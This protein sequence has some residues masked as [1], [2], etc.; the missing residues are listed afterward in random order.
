[1]PTESKA[2][3][4]T[5]F[6]ASCPICGAR[7]ASEVVTFPELRFG[8][9]AGCG[10]IYK[11]EQQPGLGDG[12]EEKYFRFTPA[13]YLARWDHRVRKCQRQILACL[14]FAPHARSLLDV[15]CSAG[16]VLA[17]AKSLGLSEMGM[18]FS[19][20]AVQLCRERGFRAERGSLDKMP[21]ADESFDIVTAKHTLEHIP[22]PIDGLR[23]IHRVLR[24]GGVAFLIVPDAAY[25]KH[26]LMPRR[27]SSFRPDRRGWQHHVYFY[28]KNLADASARAGL[29]PVK[30]GKSIFRSRLARGPRAALEYAR[31]AFLVGWT[32]GSRVTHTRREIQLIS[33]KPGTPQAL[34]ASQAHAESAAR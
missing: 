26:T 1:M 22:S 9:C 19:D 3:S 18:D 11:Q 23:E 34:P 31:Y 6:L 27:G 10:L 7:E 4:R 13:G 15:G 33:V 29:T 17:A 14:E 28:E 2:L 8:R 21:F 32:H 16:Y 30:A 20:F 24:P 5:T 25:Y 12:Y